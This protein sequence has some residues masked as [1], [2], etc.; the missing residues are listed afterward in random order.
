MVKTEALDF[1]VVEES[2]PKQ[3]PQPRLWSPVPKPGPF[4]PKQQTAD[5]MMT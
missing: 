2:E 5:G 3:C 1:E 4:P